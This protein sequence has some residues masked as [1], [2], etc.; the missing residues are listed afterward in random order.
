MV[1]MK[2][3]SDIYE[4]FGNTPIEV[5]EEKPAKKSGNKALKIFAVVGVIAA[6]V[7]TAFALYKYFKPDYL[8]DYEDDFED[9]DDELWEEE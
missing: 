3:I 2:K 6:V 5:V 1:N 9:E 7:G 8:E 4:L